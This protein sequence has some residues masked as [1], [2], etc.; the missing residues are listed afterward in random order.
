MANRADEYIWNLE[1]RLKV[2][3]TENE[4]KTFVHNFP[5]GGILT[6]ALNQP[7]YAERSMTDRLSVQFVLKIF[8]SSNEYLSFFVGE[9]MLLTLLEK[10][11]DT[12]IANILWIYYMLKNDYEKA[13]RIWRT[14]LRET[15]IKLALDKLI[16]HIQQKRDV[17]VGMKLLDLI[18]DGPF[19]FPRIKGLV[20][21]HML[22]VLG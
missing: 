7:E 16:A 5:R 13:E 15:K 20:F 21:G 1:E 19:V 12:K 6:I 11:K 10:C 3:E 2:I 17:D 22:N 8:F 18:E 9:Q 14:W 4:I